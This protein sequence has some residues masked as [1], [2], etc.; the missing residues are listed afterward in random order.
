MED[1]LA[2]FKNPI[3]IS[4]LVVKGRHQSKNTHI[5]MHFKKIKELI[6]NKL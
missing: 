3:K 6:N 1:D 2:A 5:N 4:R